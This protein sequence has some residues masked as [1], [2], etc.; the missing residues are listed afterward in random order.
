MPSPFPGMDPYLEGSE[1]DSFRAAF[2]VEI[3]RQLT[4]RL[5]PRYFAFTDRRFIPVGREKV[6]LTTLRICTIPDRRPVTVIDVLSEVNKCDEGREEHA[7]WREQTVGEDVHLLDID[8]LRAGHRTA[9][10]PPFP[11]QFPPRPYFVWLDRVDRRPVADV[12]PIGLPEQLPM[13][14]VPLQPGDADVMLDLQQTF[15]NV[16]DAF[17]YDLT[18]DY[19]H[20]PKVPLSVEEAAWARERL[21][22]IFTTGL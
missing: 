22:K 7:R 3:A 5:R 18:L 16:Y 13:V 2:V 21:A 11:D 8:L 1:W 20:P 4:P 14:P 19:A 12:W 9:G 17:G 15:T 6:P 10:R